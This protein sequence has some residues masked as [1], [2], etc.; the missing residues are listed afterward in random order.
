MK[1]FVIIRKSDI[2]EAMLQT[3]GYD[4]TK[5]VP[6]TREEEDGSLTELEY[7]L[8]PFTNEFATPLAGY[9][10]YTKEELDPILEEIR[11]GKSVSTTLKRSDKKSVWDDPEGAR[12]RFEFLGSFKNRTEDITLVYDLPEDRLING[13]R[14]YFEGSE[15]GDTISFE[16][17]H[18]LAGLLE[19]FVPSWGVCD[20]YHKENVYAAKL[21]AGLQ[22][23]I[24]FKKGEGNTGAVSAFFN[25]LLHQPPS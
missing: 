18:P 20:G 15:I 10:R 2:S 25:G 6:I 7:C 4:K 1:K 14:F 11:N 19:A 13:L 16:I 12:T 22:I 21:P 3:S 23:H 17:H 5:P 24:I 9:I 8:L